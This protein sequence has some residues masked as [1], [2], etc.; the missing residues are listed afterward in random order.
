MT[1]TVQAPEQ[2]NI[3]V[4]LRTILWTHYLLTKSWRR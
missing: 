4:R 3:R 2:T 1:I